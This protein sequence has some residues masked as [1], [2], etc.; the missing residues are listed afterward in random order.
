MILKNILENQW[1]F[2]RSS[3]IH[4][5]KEFHWSPNKVGFYK[6]KS[7]EIEYIYYTKYLKHRNNLIN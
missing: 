4:P 5:Y 7:D 2:I 3:E 1:N 6:D